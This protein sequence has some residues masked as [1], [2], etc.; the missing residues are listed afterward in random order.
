MFQ[1]LLGHLVGDYLLQTN[2]MA[3]N[4]AK[5]TWFGWYNAFIH[6]LIYT[7]AVCLLMNNFDWYWVLAVFFSHFPID[8]FSLADYY[9]HYIK[10]SG[11]K[12]YLRSK[13]NKGVKLREETLNG[14]FNAYVYALTDNTL[15]LL[16]M[17]FAYML[18]Y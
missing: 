15:H 2:E 16:I 1:M 9:M 18:I 14:G 17:Y 11:L 13:P 7:Y 10:G 8:K 12:D 5:S 4:K 3:L 6:C